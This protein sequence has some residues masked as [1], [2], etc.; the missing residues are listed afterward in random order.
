MKYFLYPLLVLYGVIQSIVMVNSL[1]LRER[2]REER[3]GERHCK[4]FMLRRLSERQRGI[5][6]TSLRELSFFVS[7]HASITSIA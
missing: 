4:P 7:P 2:E 1:L 3:E 6:L 5:V